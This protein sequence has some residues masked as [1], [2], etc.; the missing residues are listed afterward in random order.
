MTGRSTT[1]AQLIDFCLETICN[2]LGQNKWL[3]SFKKKN[4]LFQQWYGHYVRIY[5]ANWYKPTNGGKM[6]E[7]LHDKYTIWTTA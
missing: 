7:Y 2:F 1:N 6:S 5:Y 4:K 3:C